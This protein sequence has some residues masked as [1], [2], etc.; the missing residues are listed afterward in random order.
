MSFC[1]EFKALPEPGGY[2]DQPA[3]VMIRWHDYISIESEA[4]E[5]RRKIDETQAKARRN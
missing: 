2:M 3:D 1:R 5:I 4:N